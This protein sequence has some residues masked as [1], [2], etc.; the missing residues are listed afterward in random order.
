MRAIL[1]VRVSTL[2]QE[3]DEQTDNLISYAISEGYTKD[4]LIIIE[5][6]E[7]AIKL[8]EEERKGLNRMKKFIAN[9]S[10]VNCVYIW[11]LSRLT[12]NPKT[13]YS[14]RD[15]FL[16]NNV[17]LKCYSPKFQLLKNDLTDLDD[18]GS[19]LFAL[20]LQMAEAEMRNKK[21]QFRRS[22]I[23]N[24]KTGKYSGG[25]VKFG[26][27]VDD[28]GYYQINE[29]EAELIRYIFN[30]YEQG[31]SIMKLNKELIERGLINSGCFVKESLEFDGYTG[32]G[33]KYGMDRVYPQIISKEQFKSCETRKKNNNKKLD[34]TNE[35]YFGKGL[36]KCT[37]CGAKYMAMKNSI[38]YLCY[39]RFGRE[40]KLDKS[41]ACRES[42]S[43]NINILDTILFEACIIEETYYFLNNA[44]NRIQ[45]LKEQININ[46]EKIK[47]AESNIVKV[48][49][50]IERNNDMYMMGTIN[51][52]KYLDNNKILDKEK[53]KLKQIAIRLI[54]EN[55]KLEDT[56]K[57]YNSDNKSF[58]KD[59][60]ITENSVY[61]VEDLKEK[62][63]IVQRHIK[64]VN[65]VDEIPNHTK[66]VNIFFYAYPN[67]PLQYRVYIKKKPQEIEINEAF[68]NDDYDETSIAEWHKVNFKIEKRFVRKKV[69]NRIF[70][71]S[72][73]FSETLKT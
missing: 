43:I 64:E 55:P 39:N 45:E 11:E 20:Y 49:K 71:N 6:K 3:L 70:Q 32:L 51:K 56:I 35:I 31:I 54:I 27:N 18:N 26:Y 24:A 58:K 9:D 72:Y 17:Q 69:I 52:P 44:E 38:Q 60:Q 66:L 21:A 10:K 68:Y 41:K 2:A 65:I 25:F 47:T 12:R 73:P 23:R 34:K 53:I 37:H 4:N 61:A 19:L 30:R 22:K 50:K 63:K 48:D 5:D 33:T 67:R 46:K 62:Q 59:Y 29:K 36:I 1:L 14:L 28:K 16:D 57:M 13:G 7:S 8:S 15:Y 40:Q 42:A